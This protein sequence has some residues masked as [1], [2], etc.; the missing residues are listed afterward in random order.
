MLQVNYDSMKQTILNLSRLEKLLGNRVLTYI[1]KDF[2]QIQVRRV[3]RLYTHYLGV[4]AIDK[5]DKELF[6]KVV[7]RYKEYSELHPSL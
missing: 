1:E 2:Q 3:F 6:N 5:Y 4:I 7:K